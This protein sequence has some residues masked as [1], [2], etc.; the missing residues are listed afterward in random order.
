MSSRAVG[1]P[2]QAP[3]SISSVRQ[4]LVAVATKLFAERDYGKVSTRE[5]A[6]LA[7]SN[8]SMIR[9]YFGNKAGLF[10]ACIAEFYQPLLAQMELLI[11]DP[12]ADIEQMIL[13]YYEM[14]LERPNWPHMLSTCMQLD[15][16]TEQREVVE[17]VMARPH[18]LMQQ[19]L[20]R[21]GMLQ[22]G[23]EHRFAGPT[24]VSMILFPFMMPAAFRQRAGITL[25]RPTL[26][27]L[28]AHH[29]QVLRYGL[30]AEKQ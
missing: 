9:Y 23:R 25:D 8:I 20:L 19:M 6:T 5:I 4:Q 2:K 26:T 14:L 24:L 12:Q 30:L 29:A 15:S 22:P 18:H 17:R 13:C 21:Q 28:A 3:D 11:S 7:G 27:E 16:G 10:E 1:R